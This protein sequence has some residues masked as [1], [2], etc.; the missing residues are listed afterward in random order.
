MFQTLVFQQLCTFNWRHRG[1]GLNAILLDVIL[2]PAQ[3][4]DVFVR[5]AAY[6][7]LLDLLFILSGF[8]LLRVLNGNL[9]VTREVIVTVYRRYSYKFVL[10]K[11][12]VDLSEWLQEVVAVDKETRKCLRYYS[13]ELDILWKH[14]GSCLV[15]AKY[16]GDWTFYESSDRYIASLCFSYANIIIYHRNA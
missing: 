7:Q 3:Q 16:G 12:G 11:A 10:K 9:T 14:R 6:Y 13:D 5:I 4:Q 2:Q 1:G 15:F 8:C